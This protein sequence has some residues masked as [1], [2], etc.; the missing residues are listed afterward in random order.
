MYGDSKRILLSSIEDHVSAWFLSNATMEGGAQSCS[1]IRTFQGK[2]ILKVW[3]HRLQP[4]CHL[5]W[6]NQ[7]AGER[8]ALDIQGILVSPTSTV[9]V[10]FGLS[11]HW[12]EWN[13][14]F[15]QRLPSERD[16]Q[17]SL[18]KGKFS[19]GD[20]R[21]LSIPNSSS[22]QNWTQVGSFAPPNFTNNSTKV[23]RKNFT[24]HS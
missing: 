21:S 12:P 3:F 11:Y 13:Q 10:W 22:L 7:R 18:G 14:D 15:T 19:T 5:Q 9:F 20:N 6:E 24:I 17:L 8:K 1:F 2:G 4:F 23:N 16:P